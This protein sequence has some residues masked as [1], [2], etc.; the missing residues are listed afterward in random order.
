M[1]LD[2]KISN[3]LRQDSHRKEAKRKCGGRAPHRCEEA[4]ILKETLKRTSAD[5]I[6]SHKIGIGPSLSYYALVLLLLHHRHLESFEKH[7]T[8]FW[9]DK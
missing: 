6:T 8:N 1:P 5:G 7:W 2:H 9:V 4:S 3:V